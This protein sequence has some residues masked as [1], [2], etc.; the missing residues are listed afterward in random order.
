MLFNGGGCEQSDNR[1]FLQF[2]CMD[3]NGGPPVDEGN[4]AYIVVSDIKGL[5]I[6]YFEGT[7]AVGD[8]FP[9]NDSGERFEADQSIT[10]FTAD[11]NTILQQVIYHSSCSSNLE[12]KNRFGASQLVG[13]YNEEQGNITCFE[14]FSLSIDV[15]IPISV[16]GESATFQTMT[17]MTNFAGFLDLTDQVVGLTV[18]PG[19]S[20][21]VSLEGTLD[22]TERKTYS[23]L[24]TISAVLNPSGQLCQ[25]MSFDSFV[26]GHPVPEGL[27]TPPPTI[28]PTFSPAPT[29]DPGTTACTISADIKCERIKNGRAVG[30]CE[31]IPDPRGV[32]CTGG[33]PT[34][35]SFLYTGADTVT[36]S[37]EARSTTS[38]FEVNSNDI[39]TA[40]GVFNEEA[41]IDIEGGESFSIDTTCS[42]DSEPL[43]LGSVYGD[44]L[45]ELVG[46]ENGDGSFTS[47]Y[48]IQ[49]VYYI[50]NSPYAAILESALISSDFQPEPF[51][52]VENEIDLARGETLVVYKG[53]TT[54]NAQ[55]K[56]SQGI[57]FNFVLDATARGTVSGIPCEAEAVYSF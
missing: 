34:S 7:V 45:L 3:M 52:A 29:F 55:E 24:F 47:I 21:P 56:Y 5:G 35:L 18:E 54:V 20:V 26:A 44:G 13:F 41:K 39:F 53:S 17:A 31:D 11:Q 22:L 15:L 42:S 9:L 6:T 49:V 50:R 1:Q 51:E 38:T 57:V 8:E 2:T 36:I 16:A 27:P 14:T 12:L 25:G 40:S 28:A 19:G 48:P 23:S 10:I 30:G 4:E 43:V 33:Y 32:T 37:V 46:F